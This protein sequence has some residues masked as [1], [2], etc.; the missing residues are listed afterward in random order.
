MASMRFMLPFCGVLVALAAVVGLL[1][2]GGVGALGAAAGVVFMTV[3]F[4]LS[5]LFITWV[6]KVNRPMVIVAGMG[7]YALKLVVLLVTL[8]ALSG[9]A[10]LKP[11]ALGVVAGAIGW[12]AGYAW[13]VWH[14]KITLDV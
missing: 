5:T 13:W 8:T 14:A 4:V 9:W 6:D 10:G 2:R 11:M 12:A 7:A 3:L 1:F